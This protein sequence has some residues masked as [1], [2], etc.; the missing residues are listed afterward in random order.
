MSKLLIRM[1]KISSDMVSVIDILPQK[2][3][4]ELNGDSRISLRSLSVQYAIE[5]LVQRITR[6]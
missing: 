4:I 3:H 2:Y 5:I 1:Q 6:I